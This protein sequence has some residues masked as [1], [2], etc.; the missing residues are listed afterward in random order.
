MFALERNI[1]RLST[2]DRLDALVEENVLAEATAEHITTAFE[3]II[4]LR[5][6]HEIS[7]IQQGQPPSYFIDP[8]LLS[9][10]EQDLL[11][12]A[13]QAVAKFQD[14]TKRH[15]AHTPF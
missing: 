13:F 4:F 14:A 15:F 5:L 1:Q 2:L 6:R 7:L 11:R 3:A 8:Q 12:E 10:S 9:K